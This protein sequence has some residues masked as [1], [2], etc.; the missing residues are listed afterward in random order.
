M[1]RTDKYTKIE[2]RLITAKA[3]GLGVGRLEGLGVS[4]GTV[5]MLC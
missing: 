1:P 4:S 5:E 2:S 3:R